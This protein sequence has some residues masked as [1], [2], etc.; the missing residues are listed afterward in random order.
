[1][2]TRTL[3]CPECEARLKVPSSIPAGKRI[4]CPKCK[5]PFPISDEEDEAPAPSKV[6]AARSRKPAPPPEDDEDDDRE[7][8]P[9]ARKR[10]K[11]PQKA[12]SKAPLFIALGVG[13]V[14]LLGGGAA[15][16]VALWPKKQ[17]DTPTAQNQPAPLPA[18]GPAGQQTGPGPTSGGAVSAAGESQSS[19]VGRK[20]FDANNCARCHSLG[21]G[22]AGKR[23]RSRGPDL[24]RAGAKHTA[25]WLIG[26]VR[27]PKAQN[28]ESRMPAYGSKIKEE[29][30]KAL[31]EYLAHLK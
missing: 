19:A 11:K 12:A 25:E 26:Y 31:G 9:V 6:A 30:L 2:E 20:V 21:D 5:E 7:D 13:G 3:A 1:M 18:P 22:A 23:G 27:D 8:E 14:L 28:P 15:L 10:R 17:P 4:R 16:A 29:D 24:S